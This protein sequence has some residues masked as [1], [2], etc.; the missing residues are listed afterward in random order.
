V[1]AD[2]NLLQLNDVRLE[3]DLCDIVPLSIRFAESL[4]PTVIGCL[5]LRRCCTD[6][7]VLAV[8]VVSGSP[9]KAPP[10]VSTQSFAQVRVRVSSIS[11]WL[12]LVVS[13]LLILVP[14]VRLLL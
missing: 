6:E 12:V 10:Y 14:R 1:D 2:E 4:V 11:I 5:D 8:D 13:R 7:L 3:L 9:V